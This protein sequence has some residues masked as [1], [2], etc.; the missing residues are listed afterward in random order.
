MPKSAF[1]N[2]WSEKRATFGQNDY[3][4][5]LG[6]GNVKPVDLIR[7]P[8]WLIGFKG[9]ELQR[10]A[11]QVKFEGREIKAQDPE[12][13]AEIKRRIKYLNRRYS[14]KFGGKKK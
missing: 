1:K 8:K 2:N 6:N 3:I 14:V 11:R 7:G 13:F 4:D 9:N 5:I 10:I 12:K